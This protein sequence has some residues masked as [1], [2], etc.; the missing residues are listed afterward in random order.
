MAR[1]GYRPG[2]GRKAGTTKQAMESAQDSQR[3]GST[4]RHAPEN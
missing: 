4:D 3:E 2:A 1:G